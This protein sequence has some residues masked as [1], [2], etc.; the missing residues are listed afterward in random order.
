MTSTVTVTFAD[1]SDASFAAPGSADTS[2]T[3]GA[4]STVIPNVSSTLPVFVTVSCAV[5]LSPAGDL[6]RAL[7]AHEIDAVLGYLRPTI[8]ES[9]SRNRPSSMPLAAIAPDSK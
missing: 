8:S 9:L 4:P 6:D 3:P 7:D 1:A 5:P 2:H